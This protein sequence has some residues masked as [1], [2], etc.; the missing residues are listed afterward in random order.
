MTLDS[1][2][3]TRAKRRGRPRLYRRT[4][5]RITLAVAPA[6]E[7]YLRDH[8][9]ADGITKSQLVAEL[10]ARDMMLRERVI[11]IHVIDRAGYDTLRAGVVGAL[12]HRAAGSAL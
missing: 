4:T 8:A 11:A 3:K 9:R 7:R 5:T 10:I 12:V 6:V 2:P 1:S